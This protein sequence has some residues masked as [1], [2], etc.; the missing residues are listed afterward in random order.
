MTDA[1]T[2]NTTNNE[3]CISLK[4]TRNPLAQMVPHELLVKI[5]Y[6]LEER[7]QHRHTPT[8]F[9]SFSSSLSLDRSNILSCALVCRDWYY[10]AV[11]TLWREVDLQSVESFI[12]FSR[13]LDPG[14]SYMDTEPTIVYSPNGYREQGRECKEGDDYATTTE[15]DVRE[16]GHGQLLHAGNA[17]HLQH[18]QPVR[19]GFSEVSS[20]TPL[21][22]QDISSLSCSPTPGTVPLVLT[23]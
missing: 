21:S 16:R 20:R 22:E 11:D 15:H 18:K 8:S 3:S 13:V 6:N 1:P 5:F 17:T 2:D 12:Q 14:F 19:S 7:P 9:I 4:A 23:Y 10:A